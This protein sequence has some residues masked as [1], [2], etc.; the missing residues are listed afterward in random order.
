MAKMNVVVYENSELPQSVQKQIDLD[1]SIP[2]DVADILAPVVVISRHKQAR[3]G[4]GE[5]MYGI[6]ATYI[7]GYDQEGSLVSGRSL[8]E[9]NG[10]LG[11]A[12]QVA[13]EKWKLRRV[14]RAVESMGQLAT[15]ESVTSSI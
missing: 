5:L 15:V 13:L 6:N 4:D 7:E 9:R 3:Y 12:W 2:A 14:Q 8:Q 1:Q 10:L 11:R